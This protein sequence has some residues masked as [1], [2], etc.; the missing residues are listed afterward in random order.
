VWVLKF[1]LNALLSNSETLR[2]I[3]ACQKLKGRDE[4]FQK[5]QTKREKTALK[6]LEC[7]QEQGQEKHKECSQ[8]ETS[9]QLSPHSL[10][11]PF[12]WPS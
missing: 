5:K 8:R 3:K 10:E 12:I 2:E 11:S 6:T 9:L 1:G 4:E 7:F